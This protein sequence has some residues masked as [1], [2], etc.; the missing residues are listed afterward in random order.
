MVD[1][2]RI[3]PDR[4]LIDV[5]LDAPAGSLSWDRRP[6]FRGHGRSRIY[7]REISER[8][9]GREAAEDAPRRIVLTIAARPPEHLRPRSMAWAI[10][11]DLPVPESR[12][13]CL[14][15]VGDPQSIG[16]AFT[17]EAPWLLPT[18]N[19]TRGGGVFTNT[20]RMLVVFGYRYSMN[21]PAFGCRPVTPSPHSEPVQS[22]SCLYAH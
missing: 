5:L 21:S 9:C 3:R 20:R 18:H 14:T 19:V 22:S 12:T 17:I 13:S 15:A 16:S 7:S 2:R 1:W 11:A 8:L 4:R 10:G 6:S